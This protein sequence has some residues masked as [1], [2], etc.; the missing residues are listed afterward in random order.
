MIINGVFCVT[1]FNPAMV[2]K[3]SAL[4]ENKKLFASEYLMYLP[5]EEELKQLI[6]QD[7]AELDKAKE[8]VKAKLRK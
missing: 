3:Y 7:K 4:A 8:P 2:V 1:E 5:K 6:E